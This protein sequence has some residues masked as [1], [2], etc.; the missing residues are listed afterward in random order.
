MNNDSPPRR[1]R[2]R[3]LSSAAV[4]AAVW[5][6]WSGQYTPLVLA[7]GVVSAALV[8]WL[9]VHVGFLDLEAYVERRA[10]AL[11][12]FSAWLLKEIALANLA[13]ARLILTPRLPI[14]TSIVKIDAAHLS[15]VSQVVLANAITLTPGTLSVDVNGG[16][17]EVH[18]LTREAAAQVREGSMTRRVA[19]LG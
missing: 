13:V 16:Q 10:A 8:T 19:A 14:D 2:V 7:L 1:R 17:I 3:V 9:A 12:S 4:F 11:L 6:L 15:P 18:C 5:L